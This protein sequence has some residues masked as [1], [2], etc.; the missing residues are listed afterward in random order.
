MTKFEEQLRTQ[1]RDAADQAPEFHG[2]KQPEQEGSGPLD[3]DTATSR[4][5]RFA[6]TAPRLVA[7]AVAVAVAGTG[8]SWWTLNDTDSSNGVSGASCA[9]DLHFRGHT[10]GAGPRVMRTPKLG[11]SLG[12]GV[13]PGCEDTGGPGSPGK[14]P[15]E[16]LRIHKIPGVNPDIAVFANGDI[17]MNLN[18]TKRPAQMRP[19]FKPVTCSNSGTFAVS[20][21]IIGMNAQVESDFQPR[22]PYTATLVVDKGPGLALT[23]YRNVTLKV[24]VT[25]AT[26][27]GRDP[28]LLRAA[29]SEGHRV[30]AS[31]KCADHN[32]VATEFK[33]ATAS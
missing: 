25:G 2:L 3:R 15:D 20:G 30:V 27:D 6:L 7:V 18:V 22:T 9:T 12:T 8:V 19:L 23:D 14:S 10:Y 4:R 24:R 29:L 5:K 31:L 26:V 21:Q 13:M 16:H 32:F 28:G 17:W 33:L 1:L 11:P